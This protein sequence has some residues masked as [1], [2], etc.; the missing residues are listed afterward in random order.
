MQDGAQERRAGKRVEQGRMVGMQASVKIFRSLACASLFVLELALY[1]SWA[2][3]VMCADSIVSFFFL[4]LLRLGL[5]GGSFCGY[6]SF[7]FER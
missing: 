5:L 7:E 4:H 1:L 2:Y 3:D 6:G